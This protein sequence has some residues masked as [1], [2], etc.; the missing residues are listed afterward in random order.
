MLHIHCLVHARHS[1]SLKKPSKLADFVVHGSPWRFVTLQ[2]P[3]ISPQMSVKADVY[4]YLEGLNLALPFMIF[5]WIACEPHWWSGS[6]WLTYLSPRFDILK[7]SKT[8][9]LLPNK[10]VWSQGMPRSSLPTPLSYLTLT[11]NGNGVGG[12]M[13]ECWTSG[14]TFWPSVVPQ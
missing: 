2:V 6:P 8:P 14:T 1:A 3:T 13:H 10:S 4:E 12:C 5:M 9:M 11:G 7:P